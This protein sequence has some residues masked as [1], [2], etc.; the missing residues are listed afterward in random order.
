MKIIYVNC[1]LG[2][3]YESNLRSIER[4]LS[5]SE[6]K[7]YKMSGHP[8]FEPM[9]CAIPSFSYIHSHLLITC[10]FVIV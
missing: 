4:F 7:V 9:S 2:N 10:R 1:G 8:G 5:S 6:N 3:K